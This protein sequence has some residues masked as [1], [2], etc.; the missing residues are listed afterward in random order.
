MN[1]K[2]IFF[3]AVGTLIRPAESV[4]AVYAR[5]G[6]RHGFNATADAMNAAFH[7][8]WK[9]T[10]SPLHPKG[11]PPPDDDRSWWHHVAAKSFAVA[12]GKAVPGEVMEPLFHELYAH[13]AQPEAW[14][15]FEDVR[16]VLEDLTANHSLHVLSNF[17][18]RLLSILE[19]H[20]LRSLFGRIILSSEV[21]ASKPHARMFAAAVRAAQVMPAECLHVGDEPIADATG[22]EA[23]GMRC[24]LIRR[25]EQGFKALRTLLRPDS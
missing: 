17:D 19:G 2:V 18:R 9:T 21:G 7:A 4:G 22:A 15:V 20:G 10:P 11:C 8:A 16:S 24:F 6:S 13:Y 23:A 1:P 25:P 5:L 14:H 3:D 12:M